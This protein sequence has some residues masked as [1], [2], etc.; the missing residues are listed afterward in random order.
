MAS[1]AAI[2]DPPGSP[3]QMLRIDPEFRWRIVEDIETNPQLGDFFACYDFQTLTYTFDG[4]VA[5]VT[6]DEVH[7]LVLARY[8]A[9]L[10]VRI[11]PIDLQTPSESRHPQARE[12][13]F[14]NGVFTGMVQWE[15][16]WAQ[17]PANVCTAVIPPMTQVEGATANICYPDPGELIPRWTPASVLWKEPSS[18]SV[19]ADGWTADQDIRTVEVLGDTYQVAD[20]INCEYAPGT[21]LEQEFTHSL[22]IMDEQGD[23]LAEYLIER[24]SVREWQDELPKV[25]DCELHQPWSHL[26][27]ELSPLDQPARDIAEKSLVQQVTFTLRDLRGATSADTVSI[28]QVENNIAFIVNGEGY[29][30]PLAPRTIQDPATG[31]STTLWQWDDLGGDWIPATP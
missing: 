10:C 6:G 3:G 16:Y 24:R 22:V 29:D 2:A 28:R 8:G 11:Q 7:S 20:R 30:A 27:E 17:V 26:S 9:E 14:R 1:S 12:W 18:V 25:I 13:F 31:L 19:R 5:E 21:M 23:D 4:R 15:R